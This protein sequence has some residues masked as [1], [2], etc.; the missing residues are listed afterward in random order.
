MAHI[1]IIDDEELARFTIRE[2]LEV[3][4][5]SVIEAANSQDGFSC[6]EQHAPDMAIVDLILSPQMI[7]FDTVMPEK[8]GVE[9]VIR[10]KRSNP[11][12]PV[13]AISGGGQVS[14]L[15]FEN[16]ARKYSALHLAR[17]NGADSILAK[18]FSAA[19]LLEHVNQCLA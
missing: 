3:A 2:I 10:L 16:I 15:T 8:E 5:H 18:P 6:F 19:E 1:L 17:D 11:R 14:S 13:I 4:G 12:M 9:T 7:T